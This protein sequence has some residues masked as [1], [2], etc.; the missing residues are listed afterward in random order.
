MRRV[1]LAEPDGDVVALVDAVEDVGD[2]ALDA[3]RA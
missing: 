1:A 2:A 3:F